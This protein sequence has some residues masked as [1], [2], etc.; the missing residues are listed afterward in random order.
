MGFNDFMMECA[1]GRI[2]PVIICP[3]CQSQGTVRTKQEKRKSGISGGKA[4]AGILTGGASLLATGLSR[5][6]Q[7][8]KAH[9]DNC[10]MTWDF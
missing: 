10:Q 3:H 1:Y 2:N 9:C 6:Q 8:T 5:K 4:T 7:V